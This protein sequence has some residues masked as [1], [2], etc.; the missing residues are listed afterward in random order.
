MILSDRHR[1]VVAPALALALVALAVAWTLDPRGRAPADR[2]WDAP[3]ACVGERH[4]LP[5][6]RVEAVDGQGAYRVRS[7]SATLRAVR[8]EPLNVGDIL[9][10]SGVFRPDGSFV[11]DGARAH[12]W[13]VHKAALSGV[14]VL[15]LAAL[16]ALV[17]RVRRTGAGWR[18]VR[19]EVGD[20]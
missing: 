20:A 9:T 7:G 8:A 14:G 11:V 17:F 13:R 1:V 6:V 2:C 18:V 5:L 12:P 16:L 10:I 15:A 19:V 3:A 4:T